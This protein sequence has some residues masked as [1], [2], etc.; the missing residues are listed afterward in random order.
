[1]PK[2]TT[3]NN[4]IETLSVDRSLMREIDLAQDIQTKLLNAKPISFSTGK[5]VGTS[6]PARMVGGDYFD[7]VKLPN[8]RIRMI[9][10]DVMGKGIPAAM[11]MILTR[12]AFRSLAVKAD[13]PGETLTIMNQALIDDLRS[14]R[15]FVTLFC[16]DWDPLTRTLFYAN[17]GHTSPFYKK[18]DDRWQKLESKGIM[19]GGLPDQ[20]YV[21]STTVFNGEGMVLFYTDGI[22]ESVNSNG[23]QYGTQR[24]VEQLNSNDTYTAESLK[25]MILNKIQSHTCGE[26][27]KDDLTLLILKINS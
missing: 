27:Q 25:E 22:T 16:A 19:I 3:L 20:S 12:G 11:L 8:G 7:Y 15:S 17:A 24:L 18:G 14:L 5:I 26:V 6:I 23:E 9:I 13:G 21:E 2:S 4:R 1:M 10:G